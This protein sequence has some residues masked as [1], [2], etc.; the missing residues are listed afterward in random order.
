M[1]MKS[2]LESYTNEFMR[3]VGDDAKSLLAGQID[4]ARAYGIPE[5]SLQVGATAPNFSLPNATG[6]VIELRQ[7]LEHGP[8]VLVFYRGGWCPYCNIQLRS[9]QNILNIMK[10]MRSCLVAISPETPD[11]TVETKNRE[12][13]EFPVLSDTNN[14]VARQFGLVFSVSTDVITIFKNKWNLDLEKENGVSGGELPVPGTYVIDRDGTIIFC[15][16]DVDYRSRPEPE[17]ILEALR[18]CKPS[19]P[20]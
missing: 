5:Q 15:Q 7:L 19:F 12:K 16:A 4:Q 8:V 14:M 1:A 9:Y 11:N 6:E 20:E 18:Q 10:Q 17:E 13:L 2:E 3:E